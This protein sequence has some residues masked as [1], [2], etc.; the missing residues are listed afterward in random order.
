MSLARSLPRLTTSRGTVSKIAGVCTVGNI[1][2]VSHLPVM[3]SRDRSRETLLRQPVLIVNS[4]VPGQ[5]DVHNGSIHGLVLS[6]LAP[7]VMF[8][9]SPSP[10]L[11]PRQR[12][13]PALR[14]PPRHPPSAPTARQ[15]D[16]H[17]LRHRCVHHENGVHQGAAHA[18]H[19]CGDGQ[20]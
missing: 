20:S 3:L 19:G 5:Q 13:P 10:R 4:R 12:L 18:A 6:F 2:V 14:H 7:C 11:C 17:D 1:P 16:R 8:T 9:F 15:R